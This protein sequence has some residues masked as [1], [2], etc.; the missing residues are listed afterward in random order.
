M[1][2]GSSGSS[3]TIKMMSLSSKYQMLFYNP[4]LSSWCENN[5]KFIE[6]IPDKLNPD[7]YYIEDKPIFSGFSNFTNSK[8]TYFNRFGESYEIDSD[9]RLFVG[10]ITATSSSTPNAIVETEI[11]SHSQYYSVSNRTWYAT[12]DNYL[13][14][15]IQDTSQVA[16]INANISSDYNEAVVNSVC[17]YTWNSTLVG[18]NCESCNDYMNRRG[19]SAGMY[20]TFTYDS[21]TKQ[22]SK[23]TDPLYCSKHTYW[24]DCFRTIGCTFLSNVWDKGT[25][26]T[27]FSY[28]DYSRNCPL[29]FIHNTTNWGFSGF[30]IDKNE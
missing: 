8:G 28:D 25:A 2:L 14:F 19:I 11:C 12:Q 5:L 3:V 16:C 7:A 9:G 26:Y 30:D 23:V 6:I 20:N 18:V 4:D 29:N 21:T 17:S 15:E 10:S 27:T 1:V 24:L 22:W 13:T